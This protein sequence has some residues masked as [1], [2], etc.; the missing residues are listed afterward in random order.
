MVRWRWKGA[1][2]HSPTPPQCLLLQVLKAVEKA[3]YRVTTQDVAVL[4]GV[5]LSTAQKVRGGE[6]D[7]H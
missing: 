3:G 2:P 5:D 4:A 7:H 6:Q 1:S